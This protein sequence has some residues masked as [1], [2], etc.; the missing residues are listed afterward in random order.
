MAPNSTMDSLVLDRV[1]AID[2]FNVGVLIIVIAILSS[3][4]LLAVVDYL[5][6]NKL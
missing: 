1:V 2:L 5:K 4:I 6:H 3:L